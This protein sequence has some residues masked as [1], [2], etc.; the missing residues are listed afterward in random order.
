LTAVRAR[1]RPHPKGFGFATPVAADGATPRS[2]MLPSEDG[3][4]TVDS[5]F[6]PPPVAAGRIDADLLELEVEVDEKGASAS[7]ATLVQ[8]PRRML[9]GTVVQGPGA[10]VLE[11][12]GQIGSGWV[13]LEPGLSVQL[14]QA[15][16]R[17]VVVLVGDAEDGSP[18]GRVLVAGPHVVGSPTA[19]RAA[20][21]VV[22][23]GSADPSTI[24][25]GAAGAGLEP[26]DAAA[27]AT[28]L[29]GLLAGGGRGGAMGL[30]RDGPVPGAGLERADRTDEVT[31]TVDDRSTRDV[32]DA[33]HAR[34]DGDPGSAIDVVV[35]I[36]DVAGAVGIGSAA[37][38]YARVVA[39][40]AYLTVGDN[41]PMLDPLLAEDAL[42]LLPGEERGSLAVRFLVTPDG[43]VQDVTPEVAVMRSD[44]KCSYAALE[45]WLAGEP[46]ALAA[47]VHDPTMVD[48]VDGALTAL[49]EA[50]RRLGVERD[51]RATIEELFADVEV[52][53]AVIDGKLRTRDAEPHAAAY[54]VVERLMVAANESVAGWL[55]KREVPALYRAHS[56]LDRDALP[57]LRAAL[58]LLDE[59]ESQAPSVPAL[60]APDDEVD[61][62]RALTEL[63][64]AVDALAG[65]GEE[66]GRDLLVAVITGS[67]S[68]ASYEP[69][70][71]GHRGLAADA[72]VH[73]TSPIRR[74]ADLVVHRQLRAALAGEQV[75]HD[76]DALR[77]MATWLDARA[78]AI[79]WLQGRE[80]NELWAILLD[81]G[82]LDGPEPAVV[83]GVTRNGLRLRVP[84]IGVRGFVPAEAA[85]DLPRGE[86]GSFEVDEHDLTT[87]SGPWRVGSRVRVKA[88]RRDGSGRTTWRLVD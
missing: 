64:T 23:L 66:T 40:T 18:V 47:E 36:A 33:L 82:F 31:I 42:S 72:Y 85:L 15:V 20:A 70:P 52:E 16:G 80:R 48:A 88:G 59:G 43:G 21:V 61:V 22:A 5:V 25:G 46:D 73:Y 12:D 1:F 69:E 28:R 37:D 13:S 49:V 78:G 62:D 87:T 9:V 7:E 41:A 4:T 8:R 27:T 30:D 45:Q 17:Q 24:P 19:V 39:S 3:S 81:R 74:Y 44:A 63:V 71:V 83:T 14:Q 51:S 77:G 6:V 65:A 84:R 58:A 35:H 86:R 68:R 2:V 60:A 57:R 34:W 26:A 54:R 38:R 10:L 53:P 79:G 11:P 32:D 67:I 50:S 55:A 76:A 29:V 56:G 75:P